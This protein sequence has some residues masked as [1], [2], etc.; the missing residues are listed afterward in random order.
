MQ[1]LWRA[2]AASRRCGCQLQNSNLYTKMMQI[3]LQQRQP[4]QA[5][6]VFEAH[7]ADLGHCNRVQYTMLISGLLKQ[8]D[9]DMQWKQA[10]YEY[11][12]QL[13][14]QTCEPLDQYCYNAGINACAELG[15]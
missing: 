6:R 11:W 4:Q 3:A 10:A 8:R 14:R 2:M 7:V 9:A 15:R 12:R 13:R 5:V 1:L